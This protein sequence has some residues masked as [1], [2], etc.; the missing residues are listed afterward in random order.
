[1]QADGRDAKPMKKLDE[2][3]AKMAAGYYSTAGIVLKTAEQILRNHPSF[4]RTPRK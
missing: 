2:V 4:L 3:R 1:M